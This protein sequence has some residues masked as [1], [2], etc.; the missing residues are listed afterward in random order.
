MKALRSDRSSYVWKNECN[1]IWQ[2]C[3]QKGQIILGLVKNREKYLRRV[4]A[5]SALS[6]DLSGPVWRM[7]VDDRRR[8]SERRVRWLL[9]N[10]GKKGP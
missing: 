5:R 7:D 4:T 8:R 9:R 6:K 10:L 3:R 2:W 1:S